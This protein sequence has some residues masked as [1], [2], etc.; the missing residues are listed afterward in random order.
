MFSDLVIVANPKDQKQGRGRIVALHIKYGGSRGLAAYP[1][2]RLDQVVQSSLMH[3][4]YG[5]RNT[6]VQCQNM[7]CLPG[8]SSRLKDVK[9]EV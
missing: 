4:L 6:N 5:L 9:C 2:K 1:P 3:E 7:L 8:Q